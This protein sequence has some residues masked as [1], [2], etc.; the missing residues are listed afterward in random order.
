MN[1]FG[2]VQM[3]KLKVSLSLYAKMGYYETENCKLGCIQCGI[4]VREGATIKYDTLYFCS[5][6]CLR[7]FNIINGKECI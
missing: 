6:D 7:D 5:N 2:M 3:K 1:L 4:E